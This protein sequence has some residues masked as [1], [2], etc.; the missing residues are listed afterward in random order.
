M[1]ASPR[2]EPPRADLALSRGAQRITRLA[3]WAGHAG[4]RLRRLLAECVAPWQLNEQEFLLLWLCGQESEGLG[5]GELATALGVSPAQMSTL[6]ERLRKRGLI[7]V[8][9][10]SH[11]RRRQVWQIAP[12]GASLLAEASAA[13]ETL[14]EQL[15]RELATGDAT[16]GGTNGDAATG[17]TTTSDDF[18]RRLAGLSAAG[19][20]LRLFDPHSTAASSAATSSTEVH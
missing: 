6:V 11:D 15:D 2:S 3:H 7:A 18:L 4:R 9:R 19:P 8:E 20:G 17:N 16:T 12:P 13:L 14:A 10:S 5:Q 1:S